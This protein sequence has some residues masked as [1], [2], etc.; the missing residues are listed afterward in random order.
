MPAACASPEKACSTR[1]AFVR[2]AFNS[3]YVSY[4]T[5]TSVRIWPLSRRT[6]SNRTVLDSTIM[7]GDFHD[8]AWHNEVDM[9][10]VCL[11][12]LLVCAAAAQG[13][14]GVTISVTRQVNA[15]PDQ[16]DFTA[17]FTVGLDT[18]QQQVIQAV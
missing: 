12:A 1:M 6:E 5:S 9:R 4:A 15:A 18:T 2:A 16:A 17:V 8:S 14:D 10:L 3:P 13:V 7:W 11:F